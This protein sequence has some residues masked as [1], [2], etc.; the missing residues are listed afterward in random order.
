MLNKLFAN[1][2]F[3][4]SLVNQVAFYGRR[5]RAESSIRRLGFVFVG[6]ALL[7]QAFAMISE[8]NLSQASPANDLINGGISSPAEAYSDCQQN[9]ARVA[10]DYG[11]ILNHYGIA[12]SD[13]SSA[14]TVS[15]KS[16]DN[17]NN[18]YSLG[19]QSSTL[20]GE[21]P[22]TINGIT[23]YWNY[24]WAWDTSST[25]SSYS[26]LKLTTTNN[27]TYYIL[28]GSGNLV[29]VGLPTPNS[30][31]NTS[32]SLTPITNAT[33]TSNSPVTVTG[34]VYYFNDT[35]SAALTGV[36]VYN[37]YNNV[38]NEPST[39]SH[40]QFSFSLP[41]G[42]PFCVRTGAPTVPYI[43]V[44]SNGTIYSDPIITPNYIKPNLLPSRV[45]TSCT[46]VGY[47]NSSYEFQ[48]AGT[49]NSPGQC[50]YGLSA[51]EGYNITF[52]KA[53][54]PSAQTITISGNVYYFNG[55]NPVA[56]RTYR[57]LTASI[58]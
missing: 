27:S 7:V 9:S 58:M 30:I 37:C 16:T 15:I 32:S 12:C 33:N 23:Y 48:V 20:A 54:K 39:D 31:S 51:N 17:Q 55:V 57:Y 3:N 44:A 41:V 25:P 50:N 18:L 1:L 24:L 26:A 8:P 43:W 40:G 47:N 45:N 5:L 22:T 6:L 19:Q 13:I 4:P 14:T 56:L 49:Q 21:T 42:T 46:V 36:P 29:S 35:G 10:P 38:T 28:L 34:T 11:T 2:P 53:T 52:T